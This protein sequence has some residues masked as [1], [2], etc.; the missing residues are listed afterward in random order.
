VKAFKSTALARELAARGHT[1]FCCATIREMEGMARAGLGCVQRSVSTRSWAD[2]EA[3]LST[4]AAAA[5]KEITA[6]WLRVIHPPGPDIT[7]I[8]RDRRSQRGSL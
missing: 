8:Q 7:D 1:G 2:A 5:K 6:E 4:S 3:A